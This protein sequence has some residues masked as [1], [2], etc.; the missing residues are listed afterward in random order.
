MPKFC[1][2]TLKYLFNREIILRAKISLAGKAMPTSVQYSTGQSIHA[3]IV[4]LI[5]PD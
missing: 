4:D 5:M 1:A 3:Q 2:F